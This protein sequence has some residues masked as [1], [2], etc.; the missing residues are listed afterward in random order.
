MAG[1]LDGGRTGLMAITASGL[2][3]LSIFFAPLFGSVPECASAGVLMLIGCF[4]MAG[5]KELE[6]G[7]IQV[8]D[9]CL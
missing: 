2:F 5:V 7:N 8:R 1:L 4:M 9:R 3:F 6:W